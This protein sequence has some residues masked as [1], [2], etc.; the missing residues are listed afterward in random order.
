MTKVVK[1]H[2]GKPRVQT[3]NTE[4]SQ[5]VQSDAHL[6]DI[7]Q[8][9]RSW[10]QGAQQSLDDAEMSFRD[11]TEFT[12]LQDAMN[13]AKEAEVEFLKLPS[14]VRELFG[15]DVA[16]WLDTSHDPEKREEI[17]AKLVEAGFIQGL[18]VVEEGGSGGTAGA[19]PE[20]KS[21]GS[22]GSE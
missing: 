8:I 10:G 20:K 15:H 6:A 19:D 7:K 2:R 12:D 14:K 16:E 4:P 1:D 9:M 3:L 5:T 11:V 13:Q 22:E 17:T 18:E 21:S